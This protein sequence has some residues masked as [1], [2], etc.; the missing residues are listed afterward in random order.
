M[1]AGL[2]RRRRPSRAGQA[3][4]RQDEPATWVG[5]RNRRLADC[6]PMVSRSRASAARLGE[7]PRIAASS[8]MDQF[9]SRK[10]ANAGALE[11]LEPLTK[12]AKQ[13]IHGRPGIV[14]FR[15]AALHGRTS[16]R[17]WYAPLRDRI[18][19]EEPGGQPWD[20]G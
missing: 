17:E 18:R 3:R 6:E 1:G 9:H 13:A 8:G 10:I 20:W 5:T 2:D 11:R 16:P 7:R 15:I 4:Q 14:G 12:L 19:V